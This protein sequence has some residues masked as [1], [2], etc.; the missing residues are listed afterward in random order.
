MQAALCVEPAVDLRMRDDGEA[1]RSHGK[2]ASDDHADD[3][4]TRLQRL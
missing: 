2:D 1:Q 3:H 4:S